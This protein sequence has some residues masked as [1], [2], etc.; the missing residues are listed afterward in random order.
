M[1]KARKIGNLRRAMSTVEPSN[2][3]YEKSP[4]YKAERSVSMS[5]TSG[6]GE[7]NHLIRFGFFT[8]SF[9]DDM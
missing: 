8:R 7:F 4:M 5:A 9:G 1:K 6:A 3:R 2:R